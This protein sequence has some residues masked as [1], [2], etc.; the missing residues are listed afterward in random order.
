MKVILVK[1]VGGLGKSGD[2]KEVSAGYARNFLIAKHLALPATTSALEK[3]QKEQQEKQMKM[4]RDMEKLLQVKNRLH[5]KTITVKAKAN[6]EIL[7]AG[8]HEKDIAHAIGENL[9]VEISPD[10]IIMPEAI[11][12]IGIHQVKVRFAKD[13]EALVSLNVVP[14]KK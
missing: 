1:D 13:A 9:G 3:I 4:V 5:N 10:L 8:L 14:I 6:K 7:F 11:K 12:S 2:V